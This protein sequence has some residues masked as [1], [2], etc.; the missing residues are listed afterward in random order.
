MADEPKVLTV[1]DILAAAELVEVASKSQRA[2]V[3]REI[4]FSVKEAEAVAAAATKE[5]RARCVQIITGWILADMQRGEAQSERRRAGGQQVG[6]SA[7]P[8]SRVGHGDLMRMQRDVRDA[9]ALI[10]SG[11]PVPK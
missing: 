8:Y 10:E 5:E 11:K 2:R 4:L 7:N 9:I 3:E 6:P 1:G